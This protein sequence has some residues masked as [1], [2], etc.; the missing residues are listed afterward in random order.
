MT[1]E[2][3]VI[4]LIIAWVATLLGRIPVYNLQGCLISY[5]LA[6]LGAVGGWFAYQR[7]LV[8]GPQMDI[9]VPWVGTQSGLMLISASV[10]ALVLVLLSR[11]AGR[12]VRPFTRRR[13]Y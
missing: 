10:G 7:F 12:P 4:L 1:I 9:D 5:V 6:S 2:T 11:R 8:T 3:L 13:R